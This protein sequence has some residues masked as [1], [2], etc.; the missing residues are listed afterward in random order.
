MKIIN[1]QVT[2]TM[3]NISASDLRHRK[4]GRDDRWK[5]QGEY[6]EVLGSL[7]MQYCVVVFLSLPPLA[8][9]ACQPLFL[10][11]MVNKAHI[12]C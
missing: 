1:H 6:K 5:G 11:V 9:V 10:F 8:Q 4:T 3:K 2:Y 12:F 7:N